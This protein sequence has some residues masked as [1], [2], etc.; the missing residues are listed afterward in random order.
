LS[1][2]EWHPLKDLITLLKPF[3]EA[4]NILSGSKYCSLS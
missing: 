1:D 2:S 3:P 4:T